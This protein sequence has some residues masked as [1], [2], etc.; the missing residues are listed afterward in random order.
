MLTYCVRCERYSAGHWGAM[1]EGG[2]VRRLLKRLA[3]IQSK[4]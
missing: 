1:I 4:G 3:E 2:Q